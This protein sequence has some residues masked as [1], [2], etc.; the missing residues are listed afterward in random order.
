MLLYIYIPRKVRKGSGKR[1]VREMRAKWKKEK[2]M[3][4]LREREEKIRR[5]KVGLVVYHHLLLCRKVKV[6]IWF[7]IW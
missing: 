3:T 6:Y 1:N 2:V 5:G 7:V 4:S